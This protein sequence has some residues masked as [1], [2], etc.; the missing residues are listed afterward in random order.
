MDR[1]P[2]V[3]NSDA[4][5]R[6]LDRGEWRKPILQTDQDRTLFLDTMAETCQKTGWQGD[7]QKLKPARRRRQETTMTLQW[8]SNRLHLG[9]AGCLANLLRGA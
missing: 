4:I 5:Y 2:P 7:A 1:K 9:V 8:I 6:V 3:E